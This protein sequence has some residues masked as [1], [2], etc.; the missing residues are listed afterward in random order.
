M[1]L[2]M[3]QAW[4]WGLESTHLNNA[5][6]TCLTPAHFWRKYWEPQGMNDWKVMQ[7]CLWTTINY[8]TFGDPDCDYGKEGNI[9]LPETDPRI[10]QILA[11]MAGLDP[12]T[13]LNSTTMYTVISPLDRTRTEQRLETLDYDTT[14]ADWDIQVLQKRFSLIRQRT[15]ILEK[16]AEWKRHRQESAHERVSLKELGERLDTDRIYF[17]KAMA[18]LSSEQRKSEGEAKWNEEALRRVEPVLSVLMMVPALMDNGMHGVVK[19]P[20]SCV[21]A[22]EDKAIFEFEGVNYELRRNKQNSREGYTGHT[23]E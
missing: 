21:R 12:D 11:L 3:P 8:V 15:T 4:I 1:T 18:E 2:P 5:S 20:W 16:R 13:N 6:N 10:D 17:R 23:L 9:G 19:V 7:S 14:Q 22:K